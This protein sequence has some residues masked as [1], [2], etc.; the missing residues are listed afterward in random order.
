[1]S[2][3]AN[4]L[5]KLVACFFARFHAFSFLV[6]D[7]GKNLIISK[8]GECMYSSVVDGSAQKPRRL[9]LQNKVLNLAGSSDMHCVLVLEISA[10]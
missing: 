10:P 4:E 6:Q 9:S 5:P 2:F 1:M 8:M 7:L 3:T